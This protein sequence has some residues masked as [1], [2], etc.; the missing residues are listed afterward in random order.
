MSAHF[1]LCF[2]GRE[3]ACL[4]QLAFVKTNLLRML[5]V[6]LNAAC[7]KVAQCRSTVNVNIM[8]NQVFVVKRNLKLIEKV[9]TKKRGNFECIFMFIRIMMFKKYIIR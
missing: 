4:T 1:V 3:I 5:F 9:S 2:G 8:K 7:R 6:A